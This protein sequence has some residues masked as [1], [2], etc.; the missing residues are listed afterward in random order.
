MEVLG[1]A[2][3]Y[4]ITELRDRCLAIIP[5]VLKPSTALPIWSTLIR[6]REVDVAAFKSTCK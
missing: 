6:L 3:Q 2:Q 1:L 4:L 5:E